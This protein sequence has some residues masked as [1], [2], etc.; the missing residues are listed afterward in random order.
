MVELAA[1]LLI[2]GGA[3]SILFTVLSELNGV[4]TGVGG[5]LISAL[6]VLMIV[7]GFQIR[8]ARWWR[9]ALNV[10]AIALFLELTL[11]PDAFATLF[12]IMDAIVLFTLIRYRAWFQ[13]TPE[14]ALAA[15]DG[16]PGDDPGEALRDGDGGPDDPR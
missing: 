9:L 6:N 11:L 10:S 8:R 14:D 16:V 3:Q 13:W 15:R 1:A 7:T 4:S 12:A 5:A 2:V